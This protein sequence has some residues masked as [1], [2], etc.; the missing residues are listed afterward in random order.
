MIN[1]IIIALGAFLIILGIMLVLAS[2]SRGGRI[3]GGGVILIGPFPIIIGERTPALIAML[4]A[5]FLLTIFL[6]F[7]SIGVTSGG[8]R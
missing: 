1:L 8:W 2:L 6:I 3:R 4:F 5:A 7:F